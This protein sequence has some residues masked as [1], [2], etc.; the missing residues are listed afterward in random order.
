MEIGYGQK[1]D[2]TLEKFI[3]D[4]TVALNNYNT[5]V[6]P[7]GTQRSVSRPARGDLAPFELVVATFA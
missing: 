1:S 2:S 5:I 4:S 7:C 6:E 3:D